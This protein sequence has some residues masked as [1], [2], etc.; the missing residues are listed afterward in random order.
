MVFGCQVEIEIKFTILLS[1]LSLPSVRV[2]ENIPP[3]EM[4]ISDTS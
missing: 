4:A 2:K 3:K 1:E